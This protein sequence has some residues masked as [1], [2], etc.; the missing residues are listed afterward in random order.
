MAADVPEKWN[1]YFDDLEVMIFSGSRHFSNPRTAEEFDQLADQCIQQ[2]HQ[3]LL[4]DEE[5][6]ADVCS[7]LSRSALMPWGRRLAVQGRQQAS[8]CKDEEPG[9]VSELLCLLRAPQTEDIAMGSYWIGIVRHDETPYI[10]GR[11]S[12]LVDHIAGR[13]K[14]R[15]LLFA[16]SRSPGIEAAGGASE[17]ADDAEVADDSA[18]VPS[19]MAGRKV[20]WDS[21]RLQEFNQLIGA[22]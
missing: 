15:C 14:I 18:G 11:L 13:G 17:A 10:T 19:G 22:R 2:S 3:R 5:L 4:E 1:E 20:I 16:R 8:C 12:W 7:R 6:V 21:Q 9:K